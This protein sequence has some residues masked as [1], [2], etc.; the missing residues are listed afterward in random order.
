MAE[1][2]LSEALQE[3]TARC[4]KMDAPLPVRLQAFADD[5][6]GLSPEFAQIVDRMVTRLERLSARRKCAEARRADARFHDA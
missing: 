3:C 1:K 4:Q 5:V 6:R 2:T